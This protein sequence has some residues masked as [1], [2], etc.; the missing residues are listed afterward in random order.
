MPD[1]F[2]ESN[3]GPS[4]TNVSEEENEGGQTPIP[5]IELDQTP[6]FTFNPNPGHSRVLTPTRTSE[7]LQ[8]QDRP[9]SI[10]ETT[11]SPVFAFRGLD[12]PAPSVSVSPPPSMSAA[13]STSVAPSEFRSTRLTSD[14]GNLGLEARMS[15]HQPRSGLN[16]A[17][18]G[19]A[20][21]DIVEN[22]GTPRVGGSLFVSPP[23]HARRRSS[24]RPTP[25]VHKV[26]DEEPPDDEF[27]H[28]DFQRR[29]SQA[30]GML[31]SLTSV[32]GSSSMHLQP[33][34][35]IRRYHEDAETHSQ[36]HPHSK[37]KIGLVGDSGVGKSSLINSLLDTCKEPLAR[38]TARG[39]ACTCVVT[40]YHFHNDDDFVIEVEMFSEEELNEQLAQL[41][42]TYRSFKSGVEPEAE[43]KA[44]LAID[45]FKSMFRGKLRNETWLLNA[46]ESDI[47]D[48]FKTWA[49]EARRLG[50][51]RRQVVQTIG[52]CSSA[53]LPLSSEPN[54]SPQFSVWPYVRKINV[55]LKS[56]VLSKGLILVDLPGLRD[57]NSARQQITQDYLWRCD[58]IFAICDIKRTVTHV[59]VK[60]VF[61][62]A[63]Q[64]RVQRVGVICTNSDVINFDELEN[65]LD[66]EEARR[67]RELNRS[68]TAVK[69]EVEDLKRELATFDYLPSEDAATRQLR[70]DLLDEHMRLDRELGAIEF[71]RLE[72]A[73]TTRSSYAIRGLRM[74]YQGRERGGPLNIFCV[75]N[76]IYQEN[77]CLDKSVSE[78]YLRL[79]GIIDLR[80]HFIATVGESQVR[81]SKNFLE[82]EVP[83]LLRDIELWVRSGDASSS[84]EQKQAVRRLL[85]NV[86]R[87]VERVSSVFQNLN[88]KPLA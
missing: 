37:R 69:T 71:D 32:L 1:Q 52:E 2:A 9:P 66:E 14:F 82:H 17:E 80:K 41:L 84:A 8:G 33:E 40:E 63:Q 15:P 75:S 58:E 72:F 81:L 78:K 42:G 64:A 54:D 7:V 70:M 45:T 21:D 20:V 31:Q 16:M 50:P 30:K 74:E 77:R 10:R 5:S 35:I 19:D 4:D 56:H 28:P 47:L 60:T 48:N 73:V 34:S 62:L 65:D 49:N 43:R 68:V 83:A 3:S 22:S 39:A 86:E 25:I 46:S 38:A 18:L 61:D 44:K 27:N 59:G 36:F 85:G 13:T 88:A 55:Y 57:L 53:L 87:N 26:E 12:S 67:I 76:K 23:G 79:S 6:G 29:L 11:H 51:P 24:P